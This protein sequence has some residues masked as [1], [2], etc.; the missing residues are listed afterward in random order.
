MKTTLKKVA[1]ITLNKDYGGV[2]AWVIKETING[3]PNGD[4]YSHKV[5][6]REYFSQLH[7]MALDYLSKGWEIE[8]KNQVQ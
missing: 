1:H 5:L 8:I 2:R 4:P 6:K 7:D 3:E